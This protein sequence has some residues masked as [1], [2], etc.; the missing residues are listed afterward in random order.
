MAFTD[1]EYLDIRYYL[2]LDAKEWDGT[3]FSWTPIRG[4]TDDLTPEMEGR[5]R[6]HL[7]SLRTLEA[8][9]LAAA[10]CSNVTALDGARFDPE[11]QVRLV[12]QQGLRVVRAMARWLGVEKPRCTPFDEESASVRMNRGG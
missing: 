10:T 1:A 7:A 8:Q 5:V 11:M 4:A 2:G 9:L 12:R 6:G 3:T